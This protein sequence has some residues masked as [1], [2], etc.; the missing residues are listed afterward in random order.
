MPIN[1]KLTDNS[2][3]YPTIVGLSFPEASH[4]L[5]LST[6][7]LARS[8]TAAIANASKIFIAG[9]LLGRLDHSEVDQHD[10][11]QAHSG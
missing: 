6:P 4:F 3:N 2:Y 5:Q 10:L 7:V 9:R 8:I 1:L 11:A